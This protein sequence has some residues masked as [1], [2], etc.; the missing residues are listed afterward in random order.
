VHQQQVGLPDGLDEQRTVEDTSGLCTLARRFYA[1]H[2]LCRR[3]GND[4]G[5]YAAAVPRD[6]RS[7]RLRR[8]VALDRTAKRQPRAMDEFLVDFVE[9][10]RLRLDAQGR[11]D[12]RSCECVEPEARLK[13]GTTGVELSRRA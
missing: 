5:S 11:R 3:Q 12:T 4:G 13:P 7:E 10:V 9:A 8:Q 6:P 2:A 1:K